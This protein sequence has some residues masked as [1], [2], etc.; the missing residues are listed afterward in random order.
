MK[1]AWL[2]TALILSVFALTGCQ[3]TGNRTTSPVAV[4]GLPL[5]LAHFTSLNPDCSAA[6]TAVVRVSKNPEHG[7]VIVRSGE[8]YSTFPPENPRQQCNFRSTNGMNVI[9]VSSSSYTG[10]DSLAVD[11]FA[12]GQ[13]YQLTFNLTVK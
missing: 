9:Y 2:L 6:G 8:G 10:P 4:S 13:E 1:R 5:K 11:G 3:T 7:V 12:G